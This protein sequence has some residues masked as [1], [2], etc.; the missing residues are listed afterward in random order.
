MLNLD[1]FPVHKVDDDRYG[2][3]IFDLDDPDSFPENFIELSNLVD[4]ICRY[5]KVSRG[6]V[7]FFR[8]ETDV[9]AVWPAEMTV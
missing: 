5:F 3:V 7:S 2:I 1:D 8:N 9:M 4:Q 6:S